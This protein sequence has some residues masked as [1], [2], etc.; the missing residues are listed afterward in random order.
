M[1]QSEFIS[2]YHMGAY[3]YL[4]T[5]PWVPESNESWLVSD[6]IHLGTEI[7]LRQPLTGEG[8]STEE[9][10]LSDAIRKIQGLIRVIKAID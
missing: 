8:T 9:E 10:E 2:Y 5:R 3:I 6:F 4:V 1:K 7:T